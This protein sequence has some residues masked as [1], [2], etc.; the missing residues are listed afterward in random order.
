[1][2]SEQGQSEP[3]GYIAVEQVLTG[4]VSKMLSKFGD[5]QGPTTRILPHS[6]SQVA[7]DNDF[8]PRGSQ[9]SGRGKKHSKG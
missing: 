9:Q 4:A 5:K 2:T 6:L 8:Q 3:A 1:M 7:I